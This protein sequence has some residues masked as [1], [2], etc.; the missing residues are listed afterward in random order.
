[1]PASGEEVAWDSSHNCDFV[2]PEH[3]EFSKQQV[4]ELLTNYGSISELWFDMGSNTPEQ[5]QELYQ[6]VHK[7]QPDCMVSGRVGNDQY[8]FAVMADNAYPE[9]ALQ[10]P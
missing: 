5:S 2:T 6:L 7:L 10:C 9:G 3:H 8:D 1:M 4:T